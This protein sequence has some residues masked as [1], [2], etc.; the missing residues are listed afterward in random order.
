MQT[1]LVV[2]RY[3]IMYVKEKTVKDK[4]IKEDNKLLDFNKKKLLVDLPT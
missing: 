2:D 4:D 3:S 1:S